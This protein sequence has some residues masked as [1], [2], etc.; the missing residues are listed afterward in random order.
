MTF[1]T[2]SH[3]DTD[4]FT[5]ED[6]RVSEVSPAE[7]TSDDAKDVI[8]DEPLGP[9]YTSADRAVEDEVA[10]ESIAEGAQKD[11]QE[12][13]ELATKADPEDQAAALAN[14]EQNRNEAI[15]AAALLARME[16][17]AKLSTTEMKR[18]RYLSRHSEFGPLHKLRPSAILLGLIRWRHNRK[19]PEETYTPRE[20][21]RHYRV[22]A[23]A[24]DALVL[25]TPFIALGLASL[26]TAAA[27][28]HIHLFDFS[29][30]G[31]GDDTTPTLSAIPETDHSTPTLPDTGSTPPVEQPGEFIHSAEAQEIADG[32]GLYSELLQL[33]VAPGHLDQA[34]WAVGQQL[35]DAGLAYLYNGPN[36]QGTNVTEWRLNGAG[37]VPKSVLEWISSYCNDQGWLTK[38]GPS[39]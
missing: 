31:G 27:F 2:E 15:E 9:D 8:P 37:N 6:V 23:I 13:E 7:L 5:D 4:P 32:E 17:G 21:Y 1:S 16:S 26:R 33:N 11:A 29:P 38:G 28:K 19:H 20:V 14:A 12:A 35:H 3:P 22:G 39:R 30:F 18:Y 34:M 24:L 36:A 10:A 25:A